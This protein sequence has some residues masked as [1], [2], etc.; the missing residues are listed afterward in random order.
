MT[1]K[2]AGKAASK[3]ARKPG[4]A[5]VKAVSATPGGT[6]LWWAVLGC[7]G[8]VVL[9]PGTAILVAMLVAPVLLVSMFPDNGP[10]RRVALASLLFGLA[11]CVPGLAQL[12]AG[13]PTVSAALAIMHRPLPVCAAWTAVLVGWFV[14]E[15]AGIVMKL[16]TDVNAAAKRRTYAAELAA[17]EEEWGPL[18]PKNR[19]NPT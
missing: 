4:R 12:W 10:G 18:P 16:V 14:G 15:I 2:A 1:V 13:D 5:P 3:T 11:G 19:I 9:S 6:G 8:V 17:L 7:G